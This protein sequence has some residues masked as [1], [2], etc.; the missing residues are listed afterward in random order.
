MHTKEYMED[1][2]VLTGAQ[3]ISSE[4]GH[5]LDKCDPVYYMG[6]CNKV[7]IDS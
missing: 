6:K 3:L 2:A 7:Q 1:I 5:Q 4:L